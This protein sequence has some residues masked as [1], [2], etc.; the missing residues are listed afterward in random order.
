MPERRRKRVRKVPQN[1]D[2]RK[3]GAAVIFALAC[4]IA[5]PLVPPWWG[6]AL[7]VFAL[8]LWLYSLA[9]VEKWAVSHIQTNPISSSISAVIF[10]AI[11]AI[12]IVQGWHAFRKIPSASAQ[13]QPP[14]PPFKP[15]LS[16]ATDP[17][18]VA[19]TQPLA[20]I[21]KAEGKKA[22][23]KE[24]Q[25]ASNPCPG[26]GLTIDHPIATSGNDKATAYKVVGSNPCGIKILSP[27][28]EGNFATDY[29]I[30][31]TQTTHAPTTDTEAAVVE[32]LTKTCKNIDVFDGGSFTNNYEVAIS[33]DWPGQCFYFKGTVFDHNKNAIVHNVPLT[34]VEKAL[35]SKATPSKP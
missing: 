3:R 8:F 13:Q 5:S 32:M 26:G 34:A 6:V 19:K 17:P 12:P 2:G 20:P 25:A 28:A 1:R 10:L 15:A 31:G 27:K 33:S 23:K 18:N 29:D 9:P 35:E 7:A 4:N 30:Q 22:E 21:A 14:V 16:P 24:Q 11:I